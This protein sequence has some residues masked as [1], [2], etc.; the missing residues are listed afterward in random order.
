ME[1]LFEKLGD[2]DLEKERV[3]EEWFERR[4][5]MCKRRVL[6]GGLD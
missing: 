1:N 2:R 6:E 4:G 3:E 5:G